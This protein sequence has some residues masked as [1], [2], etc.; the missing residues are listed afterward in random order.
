MRV[1][2]RHRKLRTLPAGLTEGDEVE[3]MRLDGFVVVVRDRN[4]QD[5]PVCIDNVAS[6]D[7][8]FVNGRWVPVDQFQH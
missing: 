3:V 8:V 6:P 7:F 2:V 4:G 5:W 1:R